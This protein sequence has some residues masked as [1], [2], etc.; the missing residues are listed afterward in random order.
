MKNQFKDDVNVKDIIDRILW[1]E[2]L[3]IHKFINKLDRQKRWR[4][5]SLEKLWEE[6]YE[7]VC[8]LYG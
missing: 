7:E 3:A 8:E 4:K 2:H 5:S 1:K 6:T